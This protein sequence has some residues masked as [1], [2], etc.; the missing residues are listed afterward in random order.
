MSSD[1]WN[2]GDFYDPIL[3]QLD[4]NESRGLK[5]RERSDFLTRL[6]HLEKKCDMVDNQAEKYLNIFGR[7]SETVDTKLIKKQRKL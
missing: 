6:Q 2:L 3:L 1:K 4:T 7:F 5:L